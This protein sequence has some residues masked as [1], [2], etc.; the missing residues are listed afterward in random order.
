M[1]APIPA[2]RLDRFR[3]AFAESPPLWW[4]MLYF[5]CLLTGYYILRPVRE[6]MGA[7]RDGRKM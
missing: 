4:A 7:S 5:F 1:N 6:A 2:N 3:A